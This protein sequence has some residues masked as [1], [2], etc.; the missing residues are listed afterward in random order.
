MVVTTLVLSI[1]SAILAGILILIQIVALFGVPRHQCYPCPVSNS[2]QPLNSTFPM[3]KP[4]EGFNNDEE[5]CSRPSDHWDRED[6]EGYWGPDTLVYLIL[7]LVMLGLAIYSATIACL[8]KEER[9]PGMVWTQGEKV[10]PRL[11]SI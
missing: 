9:L 6:E 8:V 11:L 4:E 7:G 3:L 10:W 5:C 2:T 1:I